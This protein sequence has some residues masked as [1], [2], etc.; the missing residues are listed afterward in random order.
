MLQIPCYVLEKLRCSACGGY[1]NTKP[2]VVRAEDQQQMCGKCFESLPADEKG[3]YARQPGLEILADIIQFPS[4]YDSQDCGYSYRTNCTY[5]SSNTFLG[6]GSV[7][8]SSR[9]NN[10]LLS[11]S[12]QVRCSLNY[13]I[14][15]RTY[16][17]EPQTLDFAMIL[18]GNRDNILSIKNTSNEEA[19]N[20]IEINLKG[21][22]RVSNKPE[23]VCSNIAIKP[24]QYTN[25]HEYNRRCYR[26]TEGC[27]A[28]NPTD[29]KSLCKNFSRGCKEKVQF[30]DARRHEAKCEYNNYKC[31][32]D[33]C[34]VITTLPNIKQHIK[35]D[36]PHSILSSEVSKIFGAKDETFVT[37]SNDNLFK[38]FYYY[39]KTFVEFYVVLVGSGEEASKYSYEVMVDLGDGVVSKKSKCSTWNDAMLEKGVTFDKKELLVDNDKIVEV[40]VKFRIV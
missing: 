19:L 13:E 27:G 39:Y 1:L 38:C 20:N 7:N 11:E 32:L 23:L 8:K 35:T 21:T 31:I 33:S 10:E 25:L 37:Y 26:C 34:N 5:R 30:D 3:K 9:V 28:C 12:D 16:T 15:D 36:H 6:D 22:L 29:S 17:N 4:K 2:L 24:I 14:K 40:K 18:K